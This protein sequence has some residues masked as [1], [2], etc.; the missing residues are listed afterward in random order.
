MNNETPRFITSCSTA[1][2]AILVYDSLLTFSRE[3][4]CIWRRKFSAVTVLYVLQRYCLLFS[5]VLR[6]FHPTNLVVCRGYTVLLYL[7]ALLS[8]F[9]VALFSSFRIWAISG[10]ISIPVVMVFLCTMFVPC[11][12]IFNLSRPVR[13]EIQDDGTCATILED[14]IPNIQY[15]P[16]VT[17]CVAFLADLLVLAVTWMKTA[18]TMKA[19]RQLSHFRP[20]LT[21]VLFRNGTMYFG[22]LFAVNVITL[23]LNVVDVVSDQSQDG[24]AFI[25]VND[26]MAPTLIARFMLDLRSVYC[27]TE[28]GPTQFSTLNFATSR[29]MGNLAAPVGGDSTWN[30]GPSDDVESDR[31]NQYQEST[32]PFL[33]VFAS[34]DPSSNVVSE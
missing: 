16:I 31:A 21:T 33:T 23:I 15:Y 22:A 5:M 20:K 1:S 28:D 8:L 7:S 26:A 18:D 34:D 12:N 13:F 9:G 27:P 19:S 11:I 6:Q 32:E 17:R 25:F 2:I 3:V 10:R 30:S 24:T 4:D 14:Y 29:F